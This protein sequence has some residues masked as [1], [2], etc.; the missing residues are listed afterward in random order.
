MQVFGLPRC[1]IRTARAMSR[2]IGANSTDEEAAIR[3]GTV[4]RWREAIRNG[5]RISLP[6]LGRLALEL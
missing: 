5:L 3:R 4:R 1:N 2:M 6:R